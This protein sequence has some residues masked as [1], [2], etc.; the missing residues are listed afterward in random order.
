MR[1]MLTVI[2]QGMCLSKGVIT[3]GGDVVRYNEAAGDAE[4]YH[5]VKEE[6]PC[7]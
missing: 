2:V 3:T 6:P 1:Q 7:H 5:L 4:I